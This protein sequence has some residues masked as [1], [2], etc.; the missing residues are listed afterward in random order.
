M[1]GRPIETPDIEEATPLGAAI[2]AGIGVGLYADE[3]EALARVYRSGKVY[4]PNTELTPMYAERFEVYK[5]LYPATK[6][7][8]HK[9]A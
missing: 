9:L 7:I 6:P 8:N 4:E 5:Q 2:L 3:D 1:V